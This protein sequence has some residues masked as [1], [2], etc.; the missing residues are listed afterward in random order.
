MKLLA[1]TLMMLLACPTPSSF[2]VPNQSRDQPGASKNQVP[3]VAFV[4]PSRPART[5]APQSKLPRPVP[6]PKAASPSTSKSVGVTSWE[7]QTLALVNQ[8][9]AEGAVCGGNYHAPAGPLTFNA[10]LQVAADKHSKDMHNR[11]FFGHENPS[12]HDPFD[13]MRAAGY[14]YRTA[15]ENVAAGQRSPEQ[16]V[17]AW[18]DSPGHCV[19][20]MNPKFVETGL[21]HVVAQGGYGHYW[22]Q[23]FGRR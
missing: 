3:R 11:G 9:R 18:M 4:R 10:R 7:V 15:G 6:K 20:I 19:N 14:R 16:V 13:R 12:G 23:K 8:R 21:G 22:T 2:G 17:Q 5:K 1:T